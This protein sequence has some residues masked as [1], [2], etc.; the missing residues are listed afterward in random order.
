MAHREQRQFF[1]RVKHM[2]PWSFKDVHV[3]DCGSLDV[4]GSLRDLFE[5][6][7]Y[8]GIDIVPGRNVDIVSPVHEFGLMLSKPAD[9]LFD[10]I[11]SGEMLEHDP[12]WRESLKRMYELLKPHGLLAISCAGPG[13]P[14]HGTRRSGTGV[15]T[16]PATPDYYLNISER[17]IAEAFGLEWFSKENAAVTSVMPVREPVPFKWWELRGRHTW[18]QDTYFWGMKAG[19]SCKLV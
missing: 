5:G 15:W 16:N 14:E 1:E 7:S 6:G 9:E 3:L 2:H 13:R 17:D 10:T 19:D 18:P 4:N 12:H 8:T 11:V